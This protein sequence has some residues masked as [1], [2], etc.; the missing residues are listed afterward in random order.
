MKIRDHVE[1]WMRERSLTY[2][3]AA[4]IVG[5]SAPALHTGLRRGTFSRLTVAKLLK[6]VP[7]L[8]WEDFLLPEEKAEL[9]RVK[10]A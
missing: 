5:I 7:G 1:A 8:R 9:R 3:R 10:A 4:D 2:A 6:L